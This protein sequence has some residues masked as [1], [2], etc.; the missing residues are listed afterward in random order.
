VPDSWILRFRR[1]LAGWI[2]LTL[3]GPPASV[4]TGPDDP[5][6]WQAIDYIH[7]QLTEQLKNQNAVWA[8]MD[9][10]LRLILGITG[11]VFAA[12]LGFQRAA[13]YLLF[14]VGALTIVSVVLFMVAASIAA[15]AFRT[16]DFNWPPS[17]QGLYQGYLQHDP[18]MAKRSTCLA[19][20]FA[21]IGMARSSRVRTTVSISPS[22]SRLRRCWYSGLG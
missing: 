11:I 4:P 22:R 3:L 1:A 5:E 18:R 20:I 9:G 17:P 13:T 21:Y 16:R 6:S 2:A 19:I 14:P 15:L 8:E 12:V 10:R 7:D